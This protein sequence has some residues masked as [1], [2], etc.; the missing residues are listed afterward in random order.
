MSARALQLY[1]ER[2][3]LTLKGESKAL[4]DDATLVAAGVLDGSEMVVKD[5]GPQV[6]WRT[7]FMTEYVRSFPACPTLLS[8]VMTKKK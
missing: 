8:G 6:S 5:L 7:V 4:E 2:Q 1:V 3:K